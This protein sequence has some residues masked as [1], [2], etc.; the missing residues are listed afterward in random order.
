MYEGYVGLIFD[1]DGI[2]FDIELIY[3]QVWNEVLGCYGMCFDEQV[4]VVFNGLL[5]W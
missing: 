3:W 1:M 2:I 5:I 4:M